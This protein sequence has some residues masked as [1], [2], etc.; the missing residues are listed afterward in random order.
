VS[1]A[2][3]GDTYRINVFLQSRRG[4]HLRS[5][6]QTGID[7]LHPGVSQSAR[8]HFGTAVM[9]VKTGFG[10]EYSDFSTLLIHYGG[11]NCGLFVDAVN[12]AQ[13]GAYLA[14]G[15]VLSNGIDRR[16]HCIVTALRSFPKGIQG[17]G[18]GAFVS[19]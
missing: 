15:G 4:D 13:G 18:D 16:R 8:N 9:A 5:L 11:L 3:N 2:Q 12:I 17:P 6:A 1:A 14:E 7:N 10:H 19:L